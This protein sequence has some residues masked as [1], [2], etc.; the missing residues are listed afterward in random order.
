MKR[1]NPYRATFLLFSLL[2]N[3]R[4]TPPSSREPAP[5]AATALETRRRSTLPLQSSLLVPSA[6]LSLKQVKRSI[7]QSP[8]LSTDPGRSFP[9]VGD[10]FPRVSNKFIYVNSSSGLYFLF[11]CGKILFIDK[12]GA[13]IRERPRIAEKKKKI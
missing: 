11:R 7:T 5:T 12:G 1:V 9:V 2:R 3:A 6:S 8:V 13:K 4:T 10:D